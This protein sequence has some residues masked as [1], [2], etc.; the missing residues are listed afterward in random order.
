MFRKGLF[1]AA[2]CLM[3]AL[4]MAQGTRGPFELTLSGTGSNGPNFNGFTAAATGG[5][6]YF[7][8]PDSL[9]LGIRE[10]ATY[11]DLGVGAFLDTDTRAAVDLHFPLGD[12]SQF[13]PFIGANIGYIAGGGIKNQWEAAPEGGLKYFINNST[14]IEF[15][16]EYQFFFNQHSTASSSFSN[17]EFIYSLG[18]GFRF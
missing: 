18:I 13:V 17:G 16:I 1:I 6:G 14:F 15:A 8:I 4:A 2:V 10:T 11:D 3:P 12:Q 7:I 5:L 9:E